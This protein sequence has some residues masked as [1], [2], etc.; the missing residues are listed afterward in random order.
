MDS[1][2]VAHVFSKWLWIIIIISSSNS[3]S[4]SSSSSSSSGTVAC[5]NYIIKTYNNNYYISN[6]IFFKECDKDENVE[7]TGAAAA[8]LLGRRLQNVLS[9]AIYSPSHRQTGTPVMNIQ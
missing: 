3:I 2:Y 5:F 1:W 7:V 9:S 6:K 4:S 8:S